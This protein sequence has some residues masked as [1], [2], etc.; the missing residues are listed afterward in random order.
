M[1]K[2]PCT[3]GLLIQSNC[4]DEGKLVFVMDYSN[5]SKKGTP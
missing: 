4:F 1:L 5:Y 3:S 2:T